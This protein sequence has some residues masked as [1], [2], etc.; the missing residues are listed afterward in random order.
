MADR[1]PGEALMDFTSAPKVRNVMIDVTAYTDESG[2]VDF[3][4]DWRFEDEP[5]EPAKAGRMDLPAGRV[6]YQFH[7][8]LTDRTGKN[9]EFIDPSEDAMWVAVGNDCPKR[10]GN[11]S[12]QIKFGHDYDRRHLIVDDMNSNV[13]A[14][15]FR[16]ALRFDGDSGEQVGKSARCP[17]Y[18]YDPDFKNGGGNT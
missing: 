4:H 13:P 7:F 18:E 15:L 11:G 3:T 5:G 12:G 2:L 16:Y 9:L 14:M 17:P 8:H 10:A 6:A 1:E